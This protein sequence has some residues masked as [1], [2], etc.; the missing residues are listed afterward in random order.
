VASRKLASRRLASTRLSGLEEASL[1][2]GGL[3]EG[4]LEE[5]WNRGVCLNLLLGSSFNPDPVK[6]PNFHMA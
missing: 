1:E 3:E 2:E 5:A 6:T 4:G